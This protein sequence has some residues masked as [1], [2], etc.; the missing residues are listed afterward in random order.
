MVQLNGFTAIL[1]IMSYL[2]FVTLFYLKHTYVFSVHSMSTDGFKSTL[3]TNGQIML[4]SGSSYTTSL[5]LLL[6]KSIDN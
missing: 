4:L 2:Y 5:L 3:G 1:I 6:Q